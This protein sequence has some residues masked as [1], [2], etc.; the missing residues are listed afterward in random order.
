MFTGKSNSRPELIFTFSNP[1]HEGKMKA[2]R[3]RRQRLKTLT[4]VEMSSANFV[5][6]SPEN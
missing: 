2:H 4:A 6:T 3:N 1:G 5:F